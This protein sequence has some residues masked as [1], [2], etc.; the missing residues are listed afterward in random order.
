M[1]TEEAALALWEV[2]RTR[3]AACQAE[4]DALRQDTWVSHAQSC[5]ATH[6]LSC[7]QLE[8]D[9]FAAAR[10]VIIEYFS[11]ATGRT[12]VAQ[13]EHV[14]EGADTGLHGNL[15]DVTGW[16]APVEGV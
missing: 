4:L 1:R 8:V 7:A 10:Q 3:R 6:Y 12:P 11:A 9:R 15:V 5:I 2:I 16:L 14:P 13:P